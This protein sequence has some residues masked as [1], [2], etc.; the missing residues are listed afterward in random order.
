[1][2]TR[3]FHYSVAL[4]LSA[5]VLFSCQGKD[6][7]PGPRGDAGTPGVTGPQ[8]QPGNRASNLTKSGFVKGT[9]TGFRA[10]GV[11]PLNE[12][13]NFEYQ[14]LNYRIST[15]SV[16]ETESPGIYEF[17][18]ERGD[19]LTGS[20]FRMVFFA[21]LDL[22]ASGVT[23]IDFDYSKDLGNNKMLGVDGYLSQSTGQTGLAR[24]TDLAY[25]Q[26]TGLLTGSITWTA[27]G[28]DLPN[29]ELVNENSSG[30]G[31]PFTL[32]S[33]FSV[34]APLVTSF[35]RAATSR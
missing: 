8:G 13:F 34:H 4:G 12:T 15:T 32:T 14:Y 26:S 33:S 2:L 18:V 21:P 3:L 1:M 22:S 11:T 17:T 19:S 7:D 6:G 23:V 5:V 35:R 30:S 31:Q 27:G 24:L 25:D 10:D 29:R 28:G 20:R 16:R 9:I